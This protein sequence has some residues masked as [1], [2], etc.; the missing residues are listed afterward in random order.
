MQWGWGTLNATHFQSL[1]Q[2][3]IFEENV[4]KY[5]LLFIQGIYF[6]TPAELKFFFYIFQNICNPSP[7]LAFQDKVSNKLFLDGLNE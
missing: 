5:G 6:S 7:G 1:N 3:W 2:M 4:E